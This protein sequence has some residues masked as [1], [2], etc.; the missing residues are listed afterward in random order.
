MKTVV[1]LEGV[2]G[3]WFTLAGPAA[4]DQGVYLSSDVKGLYDPPVKV[5]HEE[6]GNWPGARYLNHR[7]QKRDL[8]FAVEIMSHRS[9]TWASRESAWRKAW[10]FD[11]DCKLY[12]TTME[13][14]TRYLKVRLMESPEVDM[15]F[16]P[17]GNGINRT[18]MVCVA[19][20]PF[21]Y[22]DD[23][24]FTA[25]T[26]TD[27]R[28]NPV[29][30]GLAYPWNYKFLPKE[31][32]AIKIDPTDARNGVNPTDQ[33]IFPKWLVPGSTEPPALPWVPGTTWLGQAT[34][35]A[36]I[37]TLPDYSWKDDEN[38]KRRLRLPPLIGGLRTDEIQQFYFDGRPT[39]GSYKLKLGFETTTAIPWNATPQQVENALVALADIA[40]GDVQV[41][42]APA[43]DERQTV[44]LKGGATGGT[45]TLTLE[46]YT[47]A[48]IPFNAGPGQVYSA[49]AQLPVTGLLGVTVTQ[50][51]ENCV[52][53]FTISNEPTRGTF[54][55][56]L[57]GEVSGPIPYNATGIE[58]E[59]ALLQ[60]SSI[61]LLDVNVVK[62]VGKPDYEVRFNTKLAGVPVNKL[63]ADPSG[64]GGGAGIDVPVTVVKQG[65][66][67]Y[68]VTLTG[69]N[70]G[71]TF[72]Q[73]TG[74]ADGL[75]GGTTNYVEVDTV[76]EGS[77]P[78]KVKFQ[79]NK[80]GVNMPQLQADTAL[81]VGVPSKPV[82][83][84]STVQGG[85]TYPAENAIIDT[86]P[87][88]EQ[89]VSESGSQLW[90]R[91]NGVRF[92]HPI[93]PYTPSGKF[94]IEVSGARPGQMVTLR[95][96]RPWS[97]PWGLE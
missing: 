63:V 61:D 40:K 27:T 31:T 90:S 11:R 36:T 37:W 10:A 95:L 30:L 62:K 4:G 14:G 33:W 3:E 97:R 92:R 18:V 91:M 19:L 2:N 77:R 85:F 45:F 8:T 48:P 21:W 96:P 57:D 49:L 89:V 71:V 69:T 25:V 22:E 35:P 87:R 12:V 56:S 32:I 44:E 64:L 78:Y 76:T 72:G 66:R 58:V 81:L 68:T 42:R 9:E 60:M 23:A 38:A 55:L 93:P 50:E 54:T 29:A 52:Q 80:S 94:D 51:I 13:S 53:V 86:D 15:F 43:T 88:V 20:D 82:F 26:T 79:G 17:N 74:S 75:T 34:S 46:G 16:D 5:V 59:Q 6:P 70:H 28:F 39:G 67:V 47:T 73:M 24:V 7:V 84:A 41:T 83:V 1:E 65:Y